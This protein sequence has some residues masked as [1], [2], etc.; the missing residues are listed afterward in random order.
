MLY[1]LYNEETNTYY[2][3]DLLNGNLLLPVQNGG[4]GIGCDEKELLEWQLGQCQKAVQTCRPGCYDIAEMEI[5]LNNLVIVPE[6]EYRT[7]GSIIYPNFSTESLS[8]I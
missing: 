5:L 6:Y 2:D 8:E 4:K 1:Y 7:D 3:I